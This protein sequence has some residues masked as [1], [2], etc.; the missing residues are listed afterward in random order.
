M[1][2][3]KR[4]RLLTRAYIAHA[5]AGIVEK[6]ME[7]LSFKSWAEITS[8]TESDKGLHMLKIMI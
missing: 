6:S 5:R 4:F 8:T 2:F 3:H 1:T 7:L